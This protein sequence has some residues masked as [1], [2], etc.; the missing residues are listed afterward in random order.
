MSTAPEV[1]QSLQVVV[2]SSIQHHPAPA[3]LP[4][5]N[6]LT[7]FKIN[8]CPKMSKVCPTTGLCIQEL[9]ESQ[10]ALWQIEQQHLGIHWTQLHQ[11]LLLLQSMRRARVFPVRLQALAAIAALAALA[12]HVRFMSQGTLSPAPQDYRATSLPQRHQTG[13]VWWGAMSPLTMCEYLQSRHITVVQLGRNKAG[14]G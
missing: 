2:L 12:Q 3:Q 10:K 5:S 8:V 4:N 9:K 6:I 13:W 14:T 11:P 1:C 7:Y